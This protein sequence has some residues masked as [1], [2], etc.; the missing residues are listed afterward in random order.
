VRDHRGVDQAGLLEGGEHGVG[1]GVRVPAR[2]TI[3]PVAL[4]AVEVPDAQQAPRPR[5]WAA[6]DVKQVQPAAI[7]TTSQRTPLRAV[8]QGGVL[9]PPVVAGLCGSL[10]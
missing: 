4:V 1:V 10:A 7:P 5:R 6:V 3:V 9:S 8:R 2:P